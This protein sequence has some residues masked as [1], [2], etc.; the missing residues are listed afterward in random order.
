MVLLS[1]TRDL[2][3]RICP[4]FILSSLVEF[5][6]P[7]FSRSSLPYRP[8]EAYIEKAREVCERQIALAGARLGLLL[9]EIAPH[10]PLP[11]PVYTPGSAPSSSSSFTL[12]AAFPSALSFFPFGGRGQDEK[13]EEEDR[14]GG[15]HGE[16]VG[17]SS[18]AF[19]SPSVGLVESGLREEEKT[20]NEGEKKKRV[21]LLLNGPDTSLHAAFLALRYSRPLAEMFITLVLLILLLVLSVFYMY[22]QVRFYKYAVNLTMVVE[23]G[24]VVMVVVVPAG[25]VDTRCMSKKKKKKRKFALSPS[26]PKTGWRQNKRAREERGTEEDEEEEGAG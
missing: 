16:R 22:R 6:W 3:T 21:V 9:E 26:L 8:S 7:T 14:P 11:P 10:L 4:P 1:K 25:A 24:A 5:D 23:E 17:E 2:F 12:S 18:P 19:E 20:G 13:K 15:Q